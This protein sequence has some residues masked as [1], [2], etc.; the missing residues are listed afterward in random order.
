[1]NSY[2]IF[3]GE[4]AMPV[5]AISVVCPQG[6]G[7]GTQLSI[8]AGG[9]QI[10]VEVPAGVAPGMSFTVQVRPSATTHEDRGCALCSRS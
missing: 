9:Q 1:M 8:M 2:D 3:G 7:P 6:A 10:M 5:P 4:L